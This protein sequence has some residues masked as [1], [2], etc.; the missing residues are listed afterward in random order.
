MALS[1]DE[2][3]KFLQS[4]EFNWD[5]LLPLLIPILQ[6]EAEEGARELFLSVGLST[7]SDP[8]LWTQILQEARDAARD[9]GAK[10][11]GKRVLSDGTVVDNPSAAWSIT[12]T[13]RDALRSLVQQAVDEGWTVNQTQE[14]IRNSTAFSPSRAL[15]IART[16]SAFARSTGT[17]IAAKGAGMSMKSWILGESACAVCEANADQGR[18]PVEE[19]FESGDLYVP[20]HP[21]CRCTNGYYPTEE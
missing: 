15:T 21:N 17:F 10:L 20:A 3:D 1:Q 5:D 14:Q 16:E 9:R 13:T 4:L 19:A 8:D 12:E 7:T 2:A 11:V 18:I 6:V